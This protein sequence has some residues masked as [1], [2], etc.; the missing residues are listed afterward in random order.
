MPL[1]PVLGS[2]GRQISESYTE[3]PYLRKQTKHCLRKPQLRFERILEQI[4]REGKCT[5]IPHGEK[6]VQGKSLNGKKKRSMWNTHNLQ[7]LEI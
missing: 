5:L 1:I 6:N 3:K 7:G 4:Y 2:R